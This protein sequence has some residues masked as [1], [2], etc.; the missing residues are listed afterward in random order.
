MKKPVVTAGLL[1]L[2]AVA[3]GRDV[4]A[5]D[6]ADE[7][8]S[9]SVSWI[10][11]EEPFETAIG[12]SRFYRHAF[13]TREGL[14]RATGRWWIDDWGLVHVDGK[15]VAASAK[16]VET[17]VDLT[18][19]LAKPG[20]HVLA[21]EGKNLSGAGGV[22][23]SLALEYA[24]G[25]SDTVF[26]SGSWLCA[27]NVQNGWTAPAFD[28]SSWRPAR[29]HGDIFTAPWCGLADMSLLAPPSEKARLAAIRAARDARVEK[30]LEALARETKPVCRIVYESGKPYFDIGGRLFETAFYNCSEGWSDDNPR[31]RRQTALFRDAG[32]HVYGIG[33]H[34]PHVWRRDGSIDFADAEAKMRSV[35]S[36]DPEA[37]FLFCIDTCV[38]P[39]WW[40]DTHPDE[41]TGYATGAPSY[42]AGRQ[43]LNFVAPSMAS[44]AWRRE[45]ADYITRLVAYLESTPYAKRIFAYRPDYGVHHE[46]HYYGFAGY[47]PD[48]GKAM[49]TAFRRWLERRYKGNVEALRRAWNDGAVTFATAEV[50]RKDARLRLSAGNMRDPVKDRP[51]I[52]YERCHA[53]QV[54]DCLFAFNRAAKEACGG[55]AL[56]GNYCG[57]FFG[58]PFPAEAFHLEND[59]IL[60]SPLVDFQ[61]SPY[62]YGR[63]SRAAGNVQ[64]ARCLLEGLRRRGK[65]A[66]LEADNVTTVYKFPHGHGNF[67]SSREDDLA[68]L[69]RDF[70]QTLCWGCGYWYF[71]FGIGWYDD[72]SFGDFFRKIYAI[73]REIKDCRSVSEVLVLGD[74]E[75][76][77]L[78]NAGSSRFNDERTTDLVNALG[79]AGVPFDTASIVDLASGK[80]KDYKVYI[81]CNLH[82]HTPEK[83]RLVAD[84][85]TRG[86]T[87][88]LPAGP[89]TA[90]DL[91]TLF[92]ENGVHVWNDDPDA[93]VYAS[94]ACVG[95]HCASGGEKT[96]R[97]PRR[98]HVTMLY[99][100]RRVIAPDTD[101]IVFTQ[102][103]NG[104]S[105]TLFRIDAPCRENVKHHGKDERVE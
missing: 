70:V 37:R 58:M 75:S 103:G 19:M 56:V 44:S 94:A 7:T 34:T 80:L 11:P 86:K 30:A 68:I 91:R 32:M 67:T 27:T 35:L 69:A 47:L 33:V 23:L 26:T 57:Y 105:T 99:P 93:A 40:C 100:E 53:E 4:L 55:R 78:T 97:L 82:L 71:D 31:L 10:C 73:R 17:P 85:R 38:P 46:W 9:S 8:L 14:V 90:K 65:V 41:L 42:G 66:L 2:L 96:I 22:C 92:A 98:A 5:T 6:L 24:D 15:S 43:Y 83:D 13:T 77:M 104:M 59:A 54:R 89:M 29:R 3:A 18:A 39:K 51:A 87:V 61:C 28:D 1:L 36:I 63:P 12:K 102:P 79:H 25:M 81:F 64:Y 84:L 48:T 72:P 52:D 76:V 74:Y 20:R 62:V 101:R 45:M 60:D 50:P 49:T 95:I 88:V 16:T 21:V